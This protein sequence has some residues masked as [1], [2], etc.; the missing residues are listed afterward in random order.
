[1][2]IYL[3]LI[4][5]EIILC[6]FC[7]G[8]K[9]RKY[10]VIIMTLILMSLI[11]L[12][13]ETKGFF[14]GSD[15]VKYYEMFQNI[16][17][18]SWDGLWQLLIMNLATSGDVGFLL[19]QKSIS[20]FTSDFHLYSFIVSGLFLIPFGVFLYRYSTNIK[21]IT[22]AYVFFS[23]MMFVHLMSGAR[24]Y[25]AMGIVWVAYLYFLQ[26][27]YSKTLV[28]M[29]LASTIHF[30]S[31]IFVLPMLMS[32]FIRNV[33]VL[34]MGHLVSLFLMPIV[35]V[36]ANSI[37]VFIGDFVGSEKY[38]DYGS[39]EMAGGANTFILMMAIL[40]ILCFVAINRRVL[41]SNEF[42]R[43]LYC[44]V[45]CFTFFA[46]LIN[47]D[48][49]M[50]RLSEYFHLFL[51]LLIPISIELLFSN[52][53]EQNFVYVILIGCLSIMAMMSNR[54]YYFFWQ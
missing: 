17:H 16:A 20:I 40:S 46:P 3:F 44:M 51:V 26:E 29:F 35:Y 22:F 7:S 10:Y 4:P 53:N 12:R 13:S 11:G 38:A 27:K 2:N 32:I 34:K 30:S 33:R 28:F 50:I 48:G 24:Q 47:A 37:I 25:F 8:N 39:A 14:E 9:G 21:Q 31:I 36:M 6:L 43:K 5:I 23:V 49:A 42:I 1:M 45:P 52:K 41:N 54:T 15:V 19:L 18:S